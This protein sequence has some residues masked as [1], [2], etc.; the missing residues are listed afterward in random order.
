MHPFLAARG[1]FAV[2]LVASVTLVAAVGALIVGRGPALETA[3]FV[4]PL[5]VAQSFLG[6]SAWYPCRAVP[7]GRR[8]V[9]A[10]I[11]TH[12]V[13]SVV[14]AAVWTA[15]A[16]GHGR[17]LERYRPDAAAL[18]DEQFVVWF[19]TG[20]LFYLL[21][22]AVHYLIVAFE[23]SRE[24]ERRGLSLEVAAR[25]AE[26]RALRA[27]IDPHFLFNSLNSIASLCGSDPNAAREMSA[28][29]AEFLRATLRVGA[30]DSIPLRDEVDLVSKY[31]SVEKVRF[32]ERLRFE[33]RIAADAGGVPVPPLLLQP[34]V[35]NAVRH[36]VEHLLEGATVVLEA[37]RRDGA[38]EVR[39]T[40]EADSDRPAHR[41][42]S[43]GL[44]NVTERLEA[45][46]GRNARIDTEERDGVF[47]AEIR[48]PLPQEAQ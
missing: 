23:R 20:V 8:S 15:A 46:Y 43:L 12:A 18:R 37:S 16:Y 32:G 33:P 1:R 45:I 6:L 10:V 2:Y 39:V 38:L 31:L 25:E 21:A 26:L 13:G 44:R 29:L 35:E 36:G 48:I 41:G 34:L 24:S 7:I 28:V 3:L 5:A 11:G 47:V 9:G 42:E 17:L 22:V 4:L 14:L 40:N 27:Q 30:L 19:A